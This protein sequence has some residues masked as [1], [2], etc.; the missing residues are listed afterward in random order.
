MVRLGDPP[1]YPGVAR[2][3]LVGDPV[4]SGTPARPVATG[5]SG[6]LVRED[7]ADLLGHPRLRPPAA[8]A[9]H[10]FLDVPVVAR[11]RR[12]PAGP[13]R[14]PDGHSGLRRLTSHSDGQSLAKARPEHTNRD[15]MLLPRPPN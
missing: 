3:V 11:P 5:A 12:N 6:R 13:P 2:A 7:H 1:Y 8:L 14:A 9:R 15:L 4:R 10:R